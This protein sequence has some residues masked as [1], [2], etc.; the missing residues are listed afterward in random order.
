MMFKYLKKV[1]YRKTFF[2]KLVFCGQLEGQWWKYK[3]P[4]P[5]PNPDPDPLIRGMDPRIRIHTKMSWIRNTV[6]QVTQLNPSKAFCL[7]ISGF[8]SIRLL[9]NPFLKSTIFIG[10][11]SLFFFFIGGSG[12]VLVRAYFRWYISGVSTLFDTFRSFYL[13]IQV[14]RNAFTLIN[15]VYILKKFESGNIPDPQH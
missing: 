11:L 7:A 1:I 12:W 2:F 5:H 4:D 13:L 6:W 8:R 15:S 14:F 10:T 3:Y 9:P